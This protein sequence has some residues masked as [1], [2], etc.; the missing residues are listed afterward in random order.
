ML[1]PATMS[2][3]VSIP[4]DFDEDPLQTGC[5]CG[6]INCPE[7]RRR[8][9]GGITVIETSEALE[10]RPDGRVGVVFTAEQARELAG[11]LRK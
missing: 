5:K 7:L 3:A 4:E 1:Y 8:P 9:D 11:W 6:R 10:Q 2:D